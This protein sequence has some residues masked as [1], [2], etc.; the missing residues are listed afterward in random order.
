VR[1]LEQRGRV[2]D[3]VSFSMVTQ[4][5]NL[6]DAPMDWLANPDG[7]HPFLVFGLYRRDAERVV[8][9]GQSWVKHGFS[10]SQSDGCG[11]EC[12]RFG[13]RQFL[14]PGCSDIYG[15]A[16]NSHQGGLGPR[17]EV[18]P[19]T[20]V[21]EYSGSHMDAERQATHDAVEHRL[22]TRDEHLDPEQHPQSEFYV[23]FY[24]LSHD[25]VDHENSIGYKQFI[26]D[27]VPGEVWDV[28]L[29]D[30]VVTEGPAVDVW[31]GATR[32]TVPEGD[33]RGDGRCYLSSKVTEKADGTWHYEYSLFNLDMSRAVG[34]L[35]IPVAIGIE[36]SNLAFHAPES[37]GEGYTN[38]PWTATLGTG[39][40]VW[41]TTPFDIDA[42]S[43]PLRW[44]TLYNFSFDCD[45]SPVDSILT[46]EPFASCTP[47]MPLCPPRF[48][49]AVV[50]PSPPSARF[51]RGD[52]NVDGN[53]EVSDAI[54]TTTFL[55]TGGP[56]SSCLEAADFD[57]NDVIN[58]TDVIASLNW[59][60]L[61]G[62]APPA[63][64]AASCGTDPVPDGPL[65]ADC[66]Y[67]LRYCR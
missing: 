25:D 53:I 54:H 26:V 38:D 24:V 19:W 40:L 52:S 1:R 17:T 62:V 63:P 56:R 27:G 3:E 2:D 30:G 37:H 16:T 7:R 45:S 61:G 51:K 23:E 57:D 8:Q 11:R 18:D 20:G 55:F 60:M 41:S 59:L 65:F 32:V 15:V 46:V 29:V 35:R 67:P 14:G 43:N 10:A 33:L 5:C 49:V 9:I 64:G 22:R 6:G 39:E 4:I 28:R 66:E 13:Q 42:F 34:A 48:E 58:L 50:A 36:V 44:G 31:E 12:E 21:F 47:R